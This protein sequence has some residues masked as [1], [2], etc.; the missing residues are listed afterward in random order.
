MLPGRYT[1]NKWAVLRFAYAPFLITKPFNVVNV[2]ATG[3]AA[4]A[5]PLTITI[6]TTKVHAVKSNDERGDDSV[7][8][9]LNLGDDW[10]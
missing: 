1:A 3:T 9:L 6:L 4:A 10:C 2:T 8:L 7:A 5:T